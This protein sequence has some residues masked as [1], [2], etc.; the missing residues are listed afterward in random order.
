MVVI[1][2]TNLVWGGKKLTLVV[3]G[4]KGA[5]IGAAGQFNSISDKIVS[6]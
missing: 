1:D 4:G 5:L 3:G 6:F 2:S